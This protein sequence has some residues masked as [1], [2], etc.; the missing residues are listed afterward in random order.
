MGFLRSDAVQKTTG[1]R[2]RTSIYSEIRLGQFPSP[3]RIGKRSVAWPEDEV[4]AICAARIAGKSEA[5]I[6][7]LV[8]FLHDQRANQLDKVLAAKFDTPIS[9]QVASQ[10]TVTKAAKVKAGGAE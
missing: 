10:L 1:Y 5:E 3:I 7:H 2:A 6:K 4:Q 9:H 8:T